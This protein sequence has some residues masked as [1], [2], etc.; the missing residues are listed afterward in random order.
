MCKLIMWNLQT[1]DGCF[2]G[3]RPWDLGFHDTVWGEELQQFSI[4]QGDEVG[5][6]L[7]GRATYQGMADYWSTTTGT[8]ADFMNSV[9]K[10][11]FSRTLDAATWNNTRLVRSDATAEVAKLKQQPGK[12]LFVFGSAKLCDSLR[13]QGLFDEY[14]ICL[15]PIVL[16]KGVPLFKPGTEASRLRLLS[17][18]TLATG[19]LILK[20]APLE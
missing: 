17:S 12:D 16:G 19:A 18:R 6:L 1:L 5:T 11:V 7:F 9:P 8:I 3:A 13:R 15:A 20:Y 10:V 14:R 4:D 2:E